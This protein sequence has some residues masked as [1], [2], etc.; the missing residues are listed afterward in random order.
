MGDNVWGKF[1]NLPCLST[2]KNANYVALVLTKI[3]IFLS[4]QHQT[5]RES[6]IVIHL[7]FQVEMYY[8]YILMFNELLH[9]NFKCVLLY[10][11]SNDCP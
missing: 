3:R 2:N 4:I 5:E 1:I 6:D 9:N 10:I 7:T 8:E 11:D